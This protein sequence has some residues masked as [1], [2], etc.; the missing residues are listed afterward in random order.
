MKDDSV[1]SEIR[2]GIGLIRLNRPAKLNAWD[3]AMRRTIMQELTRFDADEGIGAIVMTGTGDRAF[4]AGQDFDEAHGFDEDEAEQWIREWGVFYSTIRSLSKPLIAALNGTAAGSAFQVALLTDMRIGHDEVRMGQPEINSG[5]A[6]ITGPWI[7]KE[8][9]G[10]ART[11]D[12]TL[13]GRLMDADEA[14]R[15]GL[16]NHIVPREQVLSKS[17]EIAAELAAKPRVAMRLDKAWLRDMNEP[18]F[19]ACIE[20]AIRAHRESYRS[21]EPIRMMAE[22]MAKRG[23]KLG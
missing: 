19:K 18:G 7:M 6:S 3:R 15:I 17:L 9:L 2:S 20:H 4:C 8:V 5:I 22:F 16:L 11:T 23:H 1:I 14:W 10:H 13:T 12:L 21:G